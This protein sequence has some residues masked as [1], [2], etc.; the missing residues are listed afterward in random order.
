[1]GGPQTIDREVS[2]RIRA[3][4]TRAELVVTD[5]GVLVAAAAM[6]RSE[7]DLIDRVA[8]RF[9]ADSEISRLQRADGEW[10]VVS[11]HLFEVLVVAVRV[12]E[13]TDGAVDP[14]VG[15]ALSLLG[16]DRDFSEIAN[17]VDGGLPASRPVPGWKS[18]EIDTST[19]RVRVPAGAH[20][21]LGATAK[22]WVADRVAGQVHGRYGCGALVSLGGDVAVAGP[23]PLG[24]F[25]IGLGDISGGVPTGGAV[26]IGAGG[27]A[28]S[29]TAVRQWRLGGHLVHHI[30]DPSTGQ[31]VEPIWRTVSV[32]AATCVDANAASTA[33]MVKGRHAIAWLTS[34]G[35]PSRLVASDGIVTCVAGWPDDAVHFT[36]VQ[37]G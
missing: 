33:A 28:T 1:V 14:T 16:Y 22:A 5:P 11:P 30:L 29:G 7:L 27:L 21:D 19:R 18:I 23:A 26:A 4:G 37:T 36:G 34:R 3:L 25:R 2:Y 12:A 8:S 35:L 20:I 31:P 24:G 32:A 6:L 10:T 13:A 9:R 15:G 17:G